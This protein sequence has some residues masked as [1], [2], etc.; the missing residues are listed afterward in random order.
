M[1]KIKDLQEI[2]GHKGQGHKNKAATVKDETHGAA[3]QR[4]KYTKE[5]KRRTG[6]EGQLI[7]AGVSNEQQVQ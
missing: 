5:G 2:R 6:G 3:N 4:L 7:R 1:N